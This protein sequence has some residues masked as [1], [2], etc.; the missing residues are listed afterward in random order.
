MI[1]PDDLSSLY[2]WYRSD[3]LSL[4]ENDDVSS[5][6]PFA[7]SSGLD[8]SQNN[9][10]RTPTYKED[11]MNG[12]PAARFEQSDDD[13]LVST[14]NAALDQ[15]HSVLFIHAPIDQTRHALCRM[16]DLSGSAAELTFDS[17][18][19]GKAA[20]FSYQS[21]SNTSDRSFVS[22]DQMGTFSKDVYL[23]G[24]SLSGENPS[25]LT[26]WRD[27][28]SVPRTSMSSTSSMIPDAQDIFT[29]GGT[30]DTYQ[31][32][33]E[34]VGRY[35]AYVFDI[36]IYTRALDSTDVRR[37]W[38]YAVDTYNL[39][40]E[41]QPKRETKGFLHSWFDESTVM[42]DQSGD[43]ESWESRDEVSNVSLIQNVSS[44]KPSFDQDGQ[45]DFVSFDR[46]NNESLRTRFQDVTG[47]QDREYALVFLYRVHTEEE[48]RLVR[49]QNN[50]QTVDFHVNTDI[51]AGKKLIGS[52]EPSGPLNRREH[53]SVFIPD[54]QGMF[55]MS[56]FSVRQTDMI[57]FYEDIRS[58]A[59]SFSAELQEDDLSAFFDRV[60]SIDLGGGEFE[61]DIVQTLIYKTSLRDDQVDA[62]WDYVQ[63]TYLSSFGSASLS[64]KATVESDALVYTFQGSVNANAQASTSTTAQKVASAST[65]QSSE[66]S[67]QY[68]PA[69]QY[70]V[71]IHINASASPFIQ[72]HKN[73]QFGAIA[74]TSNGT[75]GSASSVLEK[76]GASILTTQSMLQTEATEIHGGSVDLIAEANIEDIVKQGVASLSAISTAIHGPTRFAQSV[77]SSTSD[78]SAIIDIQKG[79]DAVMSA[80]SG[81]QVVG[82]VGI[83]IG[84]LISM[85]SISSTSVSAGLIKPSSSANAGNASVQAVASLNNAT[86]TTLVADAQLSATV[87]GGYATISQLHERN[88]GI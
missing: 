46:S 14:T 45:F 40:E 48:H 44:K 3:D 65:Q 38:D 83:S 23:S 57:D 61:G 2:A 43:V 32:V 87:P 5:W 54:V 79:A 63:R 11:I 80:S 85:S 36:L 15:T 67:S 47:L 17:Y 34:I 49:L 60:F 84:G 1:S 7:G 72:S 18:V 31:G 56:V 52:E 78:L 24:Y 13:H 76:G 64:S 8:L 68:N 77:L 26:F 86:D 30:K 69:I 28:L 41:R 9:P 53:R 37:L 21:N 59:R 16:G 22:S 27:G 35:D 51:Q 55:G 74:F 66:A 25:D 39:S 29:V 75:F 62:L 50:D 33:S 81:V 4:S 58:N 10:S 19:Q 71:D 6:T 82:T 12:H 20:Q 42:S 70:G 73:R 88:S